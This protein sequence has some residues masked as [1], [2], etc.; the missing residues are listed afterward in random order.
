MIIAAILVSAP[1]RATMGPAGCAWASEATKRALILCIHPYRA[2]PTG[3][4][5]DCCATGRGRL[6]TPD[7]ARLSPGALRSAA[8][9]SEKQPL[10]SL[11]STPA[12]QL[13]AHL[14][15]RLQRRLLQPPVGR[16]AERR[17]LK[18][19][20]RASPVQRRGRRALS[21]RDRRSWRQPPG[22]GKQL[23]GLP[24]P[25]ACGRRAAQ[26]SSQGL[27]LASHEDL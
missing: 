1:Y 15:G 7:A 18:R 16:G 12:E 25:H 23:Q 20:R 24:G 19:I 2:L 4:C 26:P 9:V 14:H 10:N 13:F 17:R 8:A 5:G 21:K 6:P 22:D 11:S 27:T 3:L